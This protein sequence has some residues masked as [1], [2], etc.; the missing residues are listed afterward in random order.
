MAKDHLALTQAAAACRFHVIAAQGASQVESQSCREGATQQQGQGSCG[1]D[2][3]THGASEGG[4][5]VLKSAVQKEKS[6]ALGGE[7]AGGE[8][9]AHRQPAQADGEHQLHQHGHPEGRQGIGAQ[10]VE[11]TSEVNL[12]LGPCDAAE[13]NAQPDHSGDNQGDDAQLQAGRQ[14]FADDRSNRLLV[15]QGLPQIAVDQAVEISEVL[16]EQ[17]LIQA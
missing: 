4:P 10:S 2:Q 15:D 1:Q 5:V 11:A 14:G 8:S 12:S 7:K 17:R 16:I 13:A 6:A 9:P 3:V